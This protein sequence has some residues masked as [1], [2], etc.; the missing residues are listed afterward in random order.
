[1]EGRRRLGAPVVLQLGIS[2]NHP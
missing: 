2:T 1:M